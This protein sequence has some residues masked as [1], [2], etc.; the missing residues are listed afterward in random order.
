MGSF[1]FGSS[2]GSSI[3]SSGGSTGGGGMGYS[4]FGGNKVISL[5]GS[6]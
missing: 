4:T 5:L 2:V 3:G 1:G 6:G